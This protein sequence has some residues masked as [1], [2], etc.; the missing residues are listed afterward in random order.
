MALT[1]RKL[2]SA[3]LIIVALALF[4]PVFADAAAGFSYPSSWEYGPY[5]QT[6]LDHLAILV[7]VGVVIILGGILSGN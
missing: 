3:T 6:I 2:A 4:I 5:V 1:G 7:A